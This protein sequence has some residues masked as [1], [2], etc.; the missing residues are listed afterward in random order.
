MV[1]MLK[2]KE[3]HFKNVDHCAQGELHCYKTVLH[4]FNSFSLLF[5]PTVNNIIR[6]GYDVLPLQDLGYL[7]FISIS[8]F[9]TVQILRTAATCL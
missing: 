9:Q 5:A 6:L 7:I 1:I 2:I 4:F 8:A 3:M